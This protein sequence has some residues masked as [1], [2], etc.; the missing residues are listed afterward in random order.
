MI[1]KWLETD[2]V[3]LVV[4]EPSKGVDIGAKQQI[5]VELRK[6][7]ENGKCVLVISS[8]FPELVTLCDRIAVVR[9]GRLSGIVEEASE[10]ELIALASGPVRSENPRSATVG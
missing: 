8:D 10:A 6:A 2:P 7:A 3:L 4:N 9:H 5:H 1:A